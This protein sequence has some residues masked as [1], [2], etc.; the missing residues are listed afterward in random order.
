MIMLICILMCV[1]IY[2]SV[3]VCTDLSGNQS[4]WG[5]ELHRQG[6][7]GKVMASGKLGGLM[8]ST[9]VEDVK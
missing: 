5:K 4:I 2:A 1:L 9:L 8:V 7:V 6:G 3:L